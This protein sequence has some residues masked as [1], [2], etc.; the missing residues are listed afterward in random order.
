MDIYQE[1]MEDAIHSV[2]FELEQ[3]I[4]HRVLDVL[5][6]VNQKTQGL[7][8]E[9]TDKIDKTQVDSEAIRTSADTRKENLLESITDTR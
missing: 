5:S 1:L 3:T 6:Y 7:R 8:K 2:R 9:L 4:K